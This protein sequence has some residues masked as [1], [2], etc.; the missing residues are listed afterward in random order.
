MKA[1]ELRIGNLVRKDEIVVTFD[2]R[3]IM[4]I[5]FSAGYAEKYS[6]I[7]LTEE[8]SLKLGFHELI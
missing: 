5:Q 1:N 7:K 2:G 6:G 3:S 4:D 8:W